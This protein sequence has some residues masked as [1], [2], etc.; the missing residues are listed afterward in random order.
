M[1]VNTSTVPLYW[2]CVMPAV[3]AQPTTDAAQKSPSCCLVWIH[4]SGLSCFF[5][6]YFFSPQNV[7][8]LYNLS[9]HGTLWG[10]HHTSPMV[11]NLRGFFSNLYT[12]IWY[13]IHLSLSLSPFP[14][15]SLSYVSFQVPEEE[16]KD[17]S[18]LVGEYSYPCSILSKYDLNHRGRMSQTMPLPLQMWWQFMLQPVLL[19]LCLLDF[20]FLC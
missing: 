18:E 6:F 8:Y 13:Q 7:I 1:P 17:P 5:I 12:W 14:S 2:T 19:F 20:C 15:L 11:S 3:L 10:H 4:S 16:K 9:T